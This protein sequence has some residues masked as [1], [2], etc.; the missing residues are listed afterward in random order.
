MLRHIKYGNTI[1][2]YKLILKPIKKD[3]SI[4]VDLHEGVQVIVPDSVSQE[5][6]DEIMYQK[7]PWILKNSTPSA[8]SKTKPRLWSFSAARR[9]VTWVE[10]IGSK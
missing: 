5:R 8:K 6:I 3:I 4:T 9:F 1:I 10:R 2:K 7:A